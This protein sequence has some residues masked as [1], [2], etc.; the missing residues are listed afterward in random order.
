MVVIFKTEYLHF[1]TKINFGFKLLWVTKDW[2]WLIGGIKTVTP[3]LTEIIND[4]RKNH[5]GNEEMVIVQ[6]ML[7]VSAVII[8]Q[9]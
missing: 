3:H 9:L 5:K 8:Y 1:C 6:D 7:N 2:T 4:S